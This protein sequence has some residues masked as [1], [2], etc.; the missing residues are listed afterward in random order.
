MNS[1]F[2]SKCWRRYTTVLPAQTIVPIDADSLSAMNFELTQ[3]PLKTTLS[4]ISYTMPAV[5][6]TP[7]LHKRRPAKR[8]RFALTLEPVEEDSIPSSPELS[9]SLPTKRSKRTN[10]LWSQSR[11][12]YGNYVEY[13]TKQDALKHREATDN[14]TLSPEPS[15]EPTTYTHTFVIQSKSPA[16]F[17]DSITVSTPPVQLPQLIHRRQKPV[18]RQS[19]TGDSHLE[20]LPAL[21]RPPRPAQSKKLA[22]AT[23]QRHHYVSIRAVPNRAESTIHSAGGSQLNERAARSNTLLR[24]KTA[25]DHPASKK[26]VE[27][28]SSKSAAHPNNHMLDQSSSSQHRRKPRL[29]S[30]VHRAGDE[31]DLTKHHRFRNRDSDHLLQPIVHSTH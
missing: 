17:I 6:S 22:N 15:T 30:R 24:S 3:S 2:S 14:R 16:I 23:S 20:L 28:T 26:L 31:I 29:P 1:P 7:A 13:L 27:P 11:P 10:E 5:L 4:S 18:R 8:V 9:P 21:A 19:L 25:K 12:L